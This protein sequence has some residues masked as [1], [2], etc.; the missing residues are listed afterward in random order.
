MLQ[1]NKM[2][3]FIY[4]SSQFLTYGTDLIH[5]LVSFISTLSVYS[6]AQLMIS[7]PGLYSSKTHHPDYRLLIMLFYITCSYYMVL[8][9]L[10]IKCS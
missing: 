8:R 10:V 1:K 5:K 7:I 2:G 9:L 4:Q 3:F 6:C